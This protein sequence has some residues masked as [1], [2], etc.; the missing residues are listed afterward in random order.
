MEQ[1]LAFDIKYIFTDNA[2]TFFEFIIFKQSHIYFST[3]HKHFIA[4]WNEIFVFKSLRYPYLGNT[5]LLP[6]K[7]WPKHQRIMTLI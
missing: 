7:V 2:S 4:M 5:E 6:P 3:F 1:K